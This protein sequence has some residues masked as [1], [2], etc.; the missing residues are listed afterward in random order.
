MNR[1][2]NKVV[3]V[4]GAAK[5]IGRGIARVFASE[6]ARVAIADLDEK[7]GQETVAALQAEGREALFH[8]ADQ[9]RWD[10]VERMARTV[11]DRWGRIDVL[12]ANAG[13]YPS[14]TIDK[15]SEADWDQTLD[16][17]LKGMFFCVKA[18]LPH[19]RRQ[20]GG[21]IVVTSSIT[22]PIT[23][24]PGWAHYGASKAG[25]LGFIRSA[26]LEVAKENITVNAIQP[27]NI[28]TEGLEGVGEDYLETMR[29][30]VPV[31]RL[32]RPEDIAYAMLF[33]A[34]DEASFI[35]GQTLVVDG[36][37]VLPESIEGL[38]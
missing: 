20:G 16:V 22:G 35:T 28:L 30:S 24:Y 34:S 27:G 7:A 36:G 14:V 18:V 12:I 19:M 29:R 17:N 11:A 25:M 13:I 3:I 2:D 32:G 37:Q 5:G 26:A 8:P 6:G 33:L 38:S 31:G 10:Q 15:M 1:M 23:G 9:T 21:R 4:T